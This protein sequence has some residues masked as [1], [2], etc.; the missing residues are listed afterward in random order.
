MAKKSYIITSNDKFEFMTTN[1]FQAITYLK[2][3]HKHGWQIEFKSYTQMWRD[4]KRK[5]VLE[6]YHNSGVMFRIKIF[7]P[8][9]KL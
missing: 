8:P 9:K 4:F 5:N 7:I 2:G 1:L 6:V 3:I